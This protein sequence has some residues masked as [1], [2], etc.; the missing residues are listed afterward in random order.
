MYQR[1]DRRLFKGAGLASDL[2]RIAKAKLTM[3]PRFE[4]EAHAPQIASDGQLRLG[5][6]IGPGT[7]ILKRVMLLEQ[8]N[9][10]VE[11]VSIVDKVAEIHDIDY[12]LASDSKTKD[13]QLKKVRQADLD[14][15][16]R[17]KMIKKKKLDKKANILL[18]EKGIGAKVQIEKQGKTAGTLAGLALG[19]PVGALLGRIAGKKGQSTLKDIAGPL[20]SM[21]DMEKSQ[22]SNAKSK[23]SSEL[24]NIG[25]GSGLLKKLQNKY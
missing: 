2:G 9:K 1:K 7:N 14:M 20:T 25:V 5:E 16:K 6:Y 8:K 23:A 17:L 15:L 10:D 18:G 13:E 12:Q 4:G 19:G 24:Q 22:L 11:P 21:S 3:K